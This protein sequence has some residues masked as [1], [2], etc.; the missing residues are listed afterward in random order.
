MATVKRYPPLW[1]HSVI[2]PRCFIRGRVDIA[3]IDRP[4]VGRKCEGMYPL[5]RSEWHSIY[6]KEQTLCAELVESMT[7]A[8]LVF[9]GNLMELERRL[10]SDN[11]YIY[12][13]LRDA[14]E[15]AVAFDETAAFNI[16]I[17]LDHVPNEAGIIAVKFGHS[18]AYVIRLLEYRQGSFITHEALRLSATCPD[19]DRTFAVL[20]THYPVEMN[21]LLD[22]NTLQHA[23][24]NGRADVIQHY[25]TAFPYVNVLKT[26]ELP[27][28]LDFQLALRGHP[29]M[30]SFAIST[31]WIGPPRFTHV[32]FALAK[33]RLHRE[34][35]DLNAAVAYGRRHNESV[36]KRLT[37]MKQ[38]TARRFLYVFHQTGV[39]FLNDDGTLPQYR[40]KFYDLFR[41][42][43]SMEEYRFLERLVEN[44]N[45]I[46]RSGNR[47]ELLVKQDDFD[48]ALFTRA[49][50]V[51]VGPGIIHYIL[52]KASIDVTNNLYNRLAA[53]LRK[54]PPM[55][56]IGELLLSLQRRLKS[57]LERQKLF[58]I[59]RGMP[60]K[61]EKQ[62]RVIE[63]YLKEVSQFL[64]DFT[65][66][67]TIT[68]V[69]T[70]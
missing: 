61:D 55:E 35:H 29:Y 17:D 52:E 28:D 70:K 64:D 22:A 36:E 20:R 6:W 4:V 18:A 37:V 42:I 27:P 30:Y 34:P 66:P 67:T 63:R 58:D 19:R 39:K 56:S 10:R 13:E 9:S 51:W 50:K 57:G 69:K 21:D 5:T 53:R 11:G 41:S 45:L 2:L 48:L 12:A 1:F 54:R 26:L 47:D 31:E 16:F 65:P 32:W 44:H 40:Q 60:T 8:G 59:V 46:A 3:G 14:F 43:D 15:V 7:L 62:R 68:S 38:V 23:I 24:F 25:M 49:I 33:G